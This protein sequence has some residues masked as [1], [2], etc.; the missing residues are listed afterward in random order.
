MS[1]L[2]STISLVSIRCNFIPLQNLVTRRNIKRWVAPTL[3]EL[4]RRAKKLGPQ[5]PEPRSGFVEWNY[6]AELFA[7]GKRLQEDFQLPLLQTAF[8]HQSYIAK[9]EVKQRELGI[10]DVDIQM[11]HN[12]DLSAKGDYIIKEYIDAFLA[13]SFPKLPAEGRMAILAH[14]MNTD[15]LSDV[16]LHLGMKDLLLDADYPPS[17]ES[18]A[19][20]LKAV[21]GA[22]A[23]SSGIERSYL[24]V[25]DFICTQLNQKDILELWNIE[26]PEDLLLKECQSRKL[27]APEP[28][29]LG[30]CGKNTVLAVYHVGIYSN[31]NLI[32]KG[33][34]E[35]IPTAIRTASLDALQAMF[36]IHDNMKPIDFKVQVESKILKINN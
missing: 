17:K 10:T 14:L 20:S 6:R 9:E 13:H 22:L 29:L 15:T 8:T 33:F 35:D 31:Q 26:N 1:I 18:M 24:F 30:D 2:R 23:D 21:I 34:G 12:K 27:S 36:G 16:A 11:S 5:K 7:F 25:R 3:R 4:N 19:Q 32:G 28:R